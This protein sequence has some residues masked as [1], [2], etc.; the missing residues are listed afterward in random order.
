MSEKVLRFP[1]IQ[2]TGFHSSI[3]NSTVFTDTFT[4]EKCRQKEKRMEGGG[5]EKKSEGTK[6]K[7][8][9]KRNER[10][11]ERW[12]EKQEKRKEEKVEEGKEE[13]KQGTH[14]CCS[15]FFSFQFHEEEK[16]LSSPFFLFSLPFSF[17]QR[18]RSVST[19]F[20]SRSKT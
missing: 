6:E 4:F 19:L 14:F 10:V 9:R 18:L 2:F 20:R 7:N 11:R 5:V 16:F 12:R 8:G 3:R 1:F 13:D 15:S 17:L